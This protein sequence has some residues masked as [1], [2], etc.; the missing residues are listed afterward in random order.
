MIRIMEAQN[1]TKAK[2]K[3]K[4]FFAFEIYHRLILIIISSSEN[5]PIKALCA[6]STS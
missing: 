5:L 4:I 6:A 3:L 1:L 2:S